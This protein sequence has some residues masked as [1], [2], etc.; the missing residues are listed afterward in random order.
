MNAILEVDLAAL[1]H[2]Y[3]FLK[4]LT[5]DQTQFLAVVKANAYGSQSTA[6]AQ[7]LQDL[8]V[9]YFA[10]AYAEE[11]KRLRKAGIHKP[12]LVFH[13]QEDSYE[14]ILKYCLEPSI[15]TL[16]KLRVF[17]QALKKAKSKRYPI[18]IKINTGLNRLG[19]EPEEVPEAIAMLNNSE[20]L[21]L[22]S[23]YSHLAESEDLSDKSF[24]LGQ[25]E[26][27]KTQTALMQ[28]QINTP[29]LNH[30]VNTSGLLNYPEAHFDMVRSGIGLYGFGND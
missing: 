6:I 28:S 9:D 17:E 7:K 18:H 14:T 15:Y 1:A 12:I 21:W 29:F 3:S 4:S 8:G 10:V 11:G 24:T 22:K 23:V 19:L 30:L 13:A 26:R 5:N 27:F 25:I 2:N 20:Y 16:N